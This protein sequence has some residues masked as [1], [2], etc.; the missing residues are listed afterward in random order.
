M[1][2]PWSKETPHELPEPWTASTAFTQ[3]AI[4]SRQLLKNKIS[5]NAAK[6]E[7]LP[8]IRALQSIGYSFDDILWRSSR[9]TAS[10]NSV[11]ESVEFMSPN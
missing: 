7:I 4:P 10:M 1:S 8:L 2:P 3:K 9:N 11:I 6:F 5:D